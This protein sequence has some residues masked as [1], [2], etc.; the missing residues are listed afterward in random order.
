MRR[1]ILAFFSLQSIGSINRNFAFKDNS[2]QTSTSLPRSARGISFYGRLRHTLV[3]FQGRLV[4]FNVDYNETRPF[5]A[6]SGIFTAPVNGTYYFVGTAGTINTNPLAHMNLVK[7]GQA[8]GSVYLLQSSR[9]RTMGSCSAVRH[10]SVG[11]E[12]WLHSQSSR[13]GYCYW[14]TTFTGFLINADD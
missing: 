6:S 3:N 5:N 10:L 8:F 4:D 1:D 2:S 12:V 11:D 13:A 9:Y 7:N 14:Y